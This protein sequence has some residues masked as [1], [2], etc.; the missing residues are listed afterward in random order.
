MKAILTTLLRVLVLSTAI[1]CGIVF[2]GPLL[3]IPANTT[4]ATIGV[5][6]PSF[7]L[8]VLMG[9]WQSTET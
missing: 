8:A 1:S 7:V 5:L 3:N 4:T 2:G 6:L 9:W